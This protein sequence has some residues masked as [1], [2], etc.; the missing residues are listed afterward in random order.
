MLVA[1]PCLYL[2]QGLFWRQILSLITDRAVTTKEKAHGFADSIQRY[3]EVREQLR[4]ADQIL[5]HAS[6]PMVELT[7][8]NRRES[9]VS[10]CQRFLRRF[11]P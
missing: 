2:S 9:I 8:R 11:R 10:A 3:I 1:S 5:E 7:W 4:E 6:M